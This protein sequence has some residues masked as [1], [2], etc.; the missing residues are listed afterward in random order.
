MP[1]PTMPPLKMPAAAVVAASRVAF[2]AWLATAAVA[3]RAAEPIAAGPFE[4]SWES[5]EKYETPAWFRDAKF[6]I[7]AHWGPQCEPEGGDWYARSLYVEGSKERELHE[8]KYGHPSKVGFKDVCREWKAAKFDPDALL[9]IFRQAGARYLVAM[10]NHHD[11]FDL[12]DSKHQPWNAAAIGPRRDIIGAWARATRAAGLRF[13][14]SVH[15]SPAW[16]WYETTRG[17]DKAGPFG[18]AAY[19]GGLTKQ[20]GT[21]QWWEGLD[22]QD[23]YAQSREP[24]S[25]EAYREKFARRVRDLVDR[26]EPD[27]LYFDNLKLPL[28]DTPRYG[29]EI[30]AHLYNGSLARTGGRNEAVMNTKGLDAAQQRCLVYDIE[31]GRTDRINAQPWQADTCIGHWHY[32]LALFEKHAY[33]T[34]AAVIPLLCDVVSKNGNLLLSVPI[35]GSGEIDTA[36]TAI[37][38]DIGRWLATNGEAIYDTRPW[39]TFGEGPRTIPEGKEK[40]TGCRG[41]LNQLWDYRDGCTPYS[42]ADIRFTRSKDGSTVYAIVLGLPQAPITIQA[43]GLTAMDGQA[44]DSVRLV[45]SD[46]RLAWKQEPGG[47]VI[48]PAAE[49]PSRHAVVFAIQ[50]LQAAGAASQS[51]P[52]RQ[53]TLE[54]HS[55]FSSNAVLQRGRPVPVWGRAADDERVTVE[56]AGQKRET[57]AKNGRFRVDLAPLEASAEGRTMT[58]TGHTT[59]TLENI[60]V[61]EVWLCSG[62]S[63]M[64]ASMAWMHKHAPDGAAA[65]AA[66]A[67][68]LIRIASVPRRDE[69]EPQADAEVAW[70]PC[71]A[72]T[73][74]ECSAVAAF[75][76]R[77]LRRALGV[78]VGLIGSYAG[79]TPA[80]AWTDHATL[81]G[82]PRLATL[83]R[84]EEERSQAAGRQPGAPAYHN[85][86]RPA[87]L[88]NGMIAPLSPY[89]IRGVIWYQGE[90]NSD[91]PLLYRT[92]FPALVGGWRRLWGQGDF[93]F[94]FVQIAPCTRWSPGL[95]EA[96]LLAWKSTPQTAMV[97]TTDVG[98]ANDSH[99]RKKEPV[100]ARLALAARALAYGEAIEYSGP[101]FDTLEVRGDRAVLHFKHTG[102]G[103]VAKDGD[104]KGFFIAGADGHFWPAR[105]EIL[106]NESPTD[107]VEVWAAEVPAPAAVRYGWAAVPDGNL[108]N[109]AGLPASP[110]RTDVSES[111][112]FRTDFPAAGGVELLADD[113]GGARVSLAHGARW[114]D[115]G[116]EV[117]TLDAPPDKGHTYLVTTPDWFHFEPGERY[118][119][120]YEYE[121]RSARNDWPFYHSFQGGSADGKADQFRGVWQAEAGSPGQREFTVIVT[122]PDAAL[123]LGVRRADFR[124]KSLTVRKLGR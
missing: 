44:I 20:D 85:K 37:L 92:L 107:T 54:P 9:A 2:C 120:S 62:Q 117:N 106:P 78:P 66:A 102:G 51:G 4:P 103:L 23:L 33:R 97:V 11:N 27:L 59:V 63:N 49:W 38:D 60:L 109:G 1:T 69:D 36:E 21:G 17:A 3:A 34:A 39:K 15:A 94:L 98:D 25:R 79:G 119:I 112:V 5:L 28:A 76:G 22:P 58:I 13:G 122:K 31:R 105:A 121:I 7:F 6:G 29:L 75:F 81:S 86:S 16:S 118:R 8:R 89:A 113:A 124:I 101:E 52:A 35:R 40:L 73:V 100:G 91:A 55:L 57:V 110:F 18:G 47:L 50:G 87:C 108:F 32:N 77:D 64:E 115:G 61:G 82:D 24:G 53:A 71:S 70:K 80:E 72:E 114:V 42:A 48:Q 96:Q 90:S 93:P 46:A 84:A 14:V 111:F 26:Y 95:R 68:P 30:A 12:W 10:A 99:P 45:G 74:A 43:L 56:F 41:E 104:L 65:I 88:Y 123:Q 19:D 83:L 67:D 116:V